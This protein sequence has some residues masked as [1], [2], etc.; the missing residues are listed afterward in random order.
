MTFG[1]SGMKSYDTENDLL[2][3]NEDV[4][5]I[6]PSIQSAFTKV[7]KNGIYKELYQREMLTGEQ[8]EQ[9]LDR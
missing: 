6:P 2:P 8:L 3:I 7:L 5:K 9:L 1:R 4:P